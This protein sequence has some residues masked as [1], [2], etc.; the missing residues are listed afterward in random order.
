MRLTRTRLIAGIGSVVTTA[1][2]TATM[3]GQAQAGQQNA[4]E[5]ASATTETTDNT[6]DRQSTAPDFLEPSELPADEHTTWFAGDA[7]AGLPDLPVFCFEGL[8]PEDGAWHRDFATD[9]D[10]GAR[11]VVIDA[12]DSGDA[13]ELAGTLEEA[14][15]DCA[16]GWL[17]DE[18]GAVAGW[19]DHG[20]VTDAGDSAHVYAVYTAP[21]EAGTNIA[22]FGVGRTGDVVTLVQWGQ[23]GSLGDAPAGDFADSLATALDRLAP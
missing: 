6:G 21:P 20:P 8:L 9:L 15:A 17:R 4:G 2:L 13:A 3:V 12:G 14:A 22:L 23:M 5:R 1:A 10:T 7:T 18:P 11:Q 16:A 19:D